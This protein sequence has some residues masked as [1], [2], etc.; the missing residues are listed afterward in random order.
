[1]PTIHSVFGLRVVIY[2]NDHRPPHIHLIGHGCEAVFN[3]QCPHGP[4]ALRVNCGFSRRDLNR[5]IDKLTDQLAVFC[6]EWRQIH[7]PDRRLI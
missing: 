7:G 2:S 4:L 5:V 1:M 6:Y 3:L